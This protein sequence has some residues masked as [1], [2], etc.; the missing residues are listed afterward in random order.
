MVNAAI[1]QMSIDL[2]QPVLNKQ[3]IINC[4]ERTEADL[5][6]FPECANSGYAFS[7]REEALAHAELIP[8]PFVDSLI[9]VAR[10]KGCYLA[11]GI[12]EKDGT[13]LRN[14]ALLVT[15]EG[16]VHIY[17]KTHL[18]HLGADRFVT[19]GNQL[20]LF[21]TGLGAVGLVICYEWRFPEVARCLAL[22]GA[23]LLIGLSN[24]PREAMATP[25]IMLPARA[26][27]NHV[28]IISANRVGRERDSDFIGRSMIIAPDGNAVATLENSREG[29]VS[30]DMDL[31]LSRKKHLIKKPKEY[32][33]DLFRDRCPFLYRT[34][35]RE[36]EHD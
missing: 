22:Q 7:S 26:V 24:W 3:K 5:L 23:D 28:W 12:L 15:T 10:A 6:V 32:E 13:E 36:T 11:V 20:P 18:P 8:G 31:S 30:A 25:T 21:S 2:G 17:R 1:F 34:I 14:T 16:E 19:P 27:E 29:V 33:I 35:V 9:T 4:A